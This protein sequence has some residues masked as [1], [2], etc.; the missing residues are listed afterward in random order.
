L[1]EEA[2]Y[3]IFVG[4]EAEKPYI[5]MERVKIDAEFFTFAAV[6]MFNRF[7]RFMWRGGLDRIYR[8]LA[9]NFVLVTGYFRL[10]HVGVINIYAVWV[11]LGTVAL[12]IL[13][14]I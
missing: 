12:M 8:R 11:V 7:Y 4:G 5:D 1:P 9:R 13:I 14:I 6:K 10:S 3:G 2:K